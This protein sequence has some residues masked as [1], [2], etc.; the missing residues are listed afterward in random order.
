MSKIALTGLVRLL[1]I[2]SKISFLV[3]KYYKTEVEVDITRQALDF[4]MPS[5]KEEVAHQT[6]DCGELSTEK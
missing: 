3:N 6:I 1:R 2:I 4:N 5:A